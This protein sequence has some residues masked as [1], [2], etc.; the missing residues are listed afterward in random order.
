MKKSNEFYYHGSP[1]SIEQFDY[2]FT[3]RGL[4]QHGPG[5]YFSSSRSAACAHTDVNHVVKEA[6]AEISPTLH[7]VRLSIKNPLDANHV[8]KI[9]ASQVARIMRS[10]PVLEEK[11]WDRLDVGSYGIEYC[12]SKT[13]KEYVWDEANLLEILC[14]LY[15]DIF[16]EDSVKE[17]ATAVR[18]VL[19]YDG[20]TYPHEEQ[21]IM[22]AW[23][24][25][26]IEIVKRT[27]M[28]Q[29]DEDLEPGVR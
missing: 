2:A 19:G 17:F 3:G 16:D 22:V 12:I 4:D 18:D 13:A 21:N 8:Q 24:P 26:Q 23:F 7:T 20:A 6:R 9:T 15:G 25:D 11:L 29:L 10:S 27:P 14:R 1:C 28:R 5:F